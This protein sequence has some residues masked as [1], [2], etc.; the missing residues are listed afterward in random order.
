MKNELRALI[1]LLI[2]GLLFM[3]FSCDVV[4]SSWTGEHYGKLT[5]KNQSQYSL[6]EIKICEYS[7]ESGLKTV[8]ANQLPSGSSRTYQNG[9]GVKLEYTTFALYGNF[10]TRHIKI[11][12]NDTQ[13]TK[14]ILLSEGHNVEI[15]VDDSG[16]TVTNPIYDPSSGQ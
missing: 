6:S 3:F 5:I 7:D 9:D 2:F 1:G 16:L 15:V 4:E 13:K 10:K 12:Y 14:G 11:R 8:D